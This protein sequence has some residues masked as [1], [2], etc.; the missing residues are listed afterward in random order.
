MSATRRPP[1]RD[2][3]LSGKPMLRKKLV[4]VFADVE[5]GFVDQRNRSDD[6]M[7]NWDLFYCK[8][9]DHQFY[10]GN[11]QI[12]M[13]Y[14][15]DAVNARKT[16]FTNQIFPRSGRYVDVTTTDGEIPHAEMALIENYVRK[17]KLR[18]EIMPALVKNGDVEGQY[19]VYVGWEEVTRHH[20]RRE[21]VA[22]QE[23]LPELGEHTEYETS[24]EKIGRPTVEVLHDGDLL[25]LPATVDNIEE[26]IEGGGSVTI[27][28]RWSKGRIRKAIADGD[29]VK[30][31][32][33][34][35]IKAMSKKG[36]GDTRDVPKDMA[37]AAGIKGGGSHAL[38]YETWTRL[39]VEG[40]ERLCR[41]YYGGEKQIL[42]C[43]LCPYWCD[44]VPV[45]TAPVDKIAGV[46]KGRAPVADVATLQIL[47]NDTINEGADTSHF[48]AMPIV[49]TDPNKNPRVGSMVLGLA[50]VWETSPQDTQF[51]QFPELWRTATERAEAIKGQIFQ[52]LGVN[53]SMVPQ[54]ASKRK[55][56]QA[57]IANEQQVDILTTADAVTVIEE[58]I[59][60]PLIQRCAEYDHQFREPIQLNNRWEFKWFGVEAARNAAQMQQQIAGINVLK[61]IPPD[62]YPGYKLNLAPVMEQMTESLFG[63]RLAPLIFVK[64]VPFSLDP[65]MENT[66][67]EH[68]HVVKVNDAD[69]DQQHIEAH[70][71]AAM[72]SQDPHGTF[73][74]H[75]A[76][77]MKSV[78]KKQ[79]AM[80][81]AQMAK[82][83]PGSPGGAGPGVAGTPPGAQPGVTH[84]AKGPPG[85]IHPDQMAAAGAVEMPRKM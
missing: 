38:V 54:G 27:L 3:E 1:K 76:Q 23:G 85:M 5:K 21:T 53:T 84:A 32:G 25:I 35:L 4:E 67:L 19:S 72:A 59:L 41:A 74:D 11:S 42:G 45:I 39:K 43:K 44:R 6:I 50:A 64:E 14:V 24:A 79:S 10:N 63:P 18:T 58:G 12:F 16:R 65:E 66:M 77:H 75:I 80:Q 78:E 40:T 31:D 70:M 57:E 55:Q 82:G 29:I 13:P 8:L 15:R 49:M 46:I 56:N 73:R 28:R 36:Q 48:S 37:E 62:Q 2:A 61:G 51:A 20:T 81:Q 17:T 68:G 83:V 9:T 22:D 47:A 52:T 60:T 69:D 26:A 30:E 7:D 33:E 34:A 71:A